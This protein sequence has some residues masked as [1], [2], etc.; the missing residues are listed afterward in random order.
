MHFYKKSITGY[1]KRFTQSSSVTLTIV[2][3]ADYDIIIPQM[4]H[5]EALFETPTPNYLLSF[6][7]VLYRTFLTL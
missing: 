6:F 7:V 4:S 5:K 1:K 3:N 2:L